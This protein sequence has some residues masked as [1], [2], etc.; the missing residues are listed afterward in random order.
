[1]ESIRNNA[2]VNLKSYKVFFDPSI[3]KKKKVEKEVNYV[4][5]SVVVNIEPLSLH[6]GKSFTVVHSL[7]LFSS[8]SLYIEML[9]FTQRTMLKYRFRKS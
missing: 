6:N 5:Q 1:M 7:I 8:L 4:N 2:A 9:N 3:R